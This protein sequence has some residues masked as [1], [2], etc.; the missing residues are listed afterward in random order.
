M[1]VTVRWI[2]SEPNPADRPSR[3]AG[4]S[5]RGPRADPR[6][7]CFDPAAAPQGD[8]Q[9]ALVAA[10]DEAL[11]CGELDGLGRPLVGVA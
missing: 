9:T 2:P 4:A 7:A 8:A 6:S 10:V 1:A 11:L 3:T 5:A